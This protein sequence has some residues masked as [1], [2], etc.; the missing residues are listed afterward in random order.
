MNNIRGHFP[1][2]LFSIKKGILLFKIEMPFS[3]LAF[4]FYLYIS[5][6]T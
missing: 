4:N 1:F 2:V 3:F 5:R 6:M